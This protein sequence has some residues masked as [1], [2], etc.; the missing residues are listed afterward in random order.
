MEGK[1]TREFRHIVKRQMIW[2]DGHYTA[3]DW[4]RH[5][6]GR[7]L[8]MTHVQWL[9]RN[10]VIHER[11]EDGLT[12]TEQEALLLKMENQ[13][14]QGEDGLSQEDTYLLEFDFESLWSKTGRQ[15]SIGCKR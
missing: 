3:E 5:V 9:Y 11:M 7:V 13:F 15:K 10:A 4:T 12:R 14:D 8:D 2:A 1:L 6:I